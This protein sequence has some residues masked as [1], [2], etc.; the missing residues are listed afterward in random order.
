MKEGELI[1]KRI[2]VLLCLVVL[3]LTG[4]GWA[5]EVTVGRLS[6]KLNS[7]VSNSSSV[8]WYDLSSPYPPYSQGQLAPP[9]VAIVTTD[10][11]VII[12]MDYQ[13]RDDSYV[14]GKSQKLELTVEQ[15]SP[16]SYDWTGAMSTSQSK[17][18]TRTGRYD[19][20][21]SLS[22]AT[23]WSSG[24]RAL[25][26]RVEGYAKSGDKT[27]TKYR[28][29]W[30]VRR[31][32]NNAAAW[33]AAP[34]WICARYDRSALYEELSHAWDQT[35]KAPTGSALKSSLD[36]IIEMAKGYVTPTASDLAAEIGLESLGV[37]NSLWTA[38]SVASEALGS[39]G[40]ILQGLGWVTTSRDILGPGLRN[41]IV[42]ATA[43]SITRQ[44]ASSA[45]GLV[46]SLKDVADKMRDDARALEGVLYSSLHAGSWKARLQSEKS[47]LDSALTS[48]TSARSSVAS[49]CNY[50][51]Y[52]T[53][54]GGVGS[55]LQSSAATVSTNL[56]Q[57]LNAVENQLKFDSAVVAKAL[58]L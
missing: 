19:V 57:F 32:S 20:S 44:A 40:I 42:S 16:D 12:K 5:L 55:G 56:N 23:Y 51:S 28:E 53:L 35:G 39:A 17:N 52:S 18:S 11:T 45:S 6:A 10:N 38:S 8:D 4:S 3:C 36:G 46:T 29:L 26:L 22:Q 13:L 49:K 25:K 43:P 54:P 31:P 41:A 9:N 15:W 7:A 48:N 1:M 14:S 27:T 30:V 47:A 58:A 34:R 2:I 37:L 21:N 33:Q 50:S 24:H